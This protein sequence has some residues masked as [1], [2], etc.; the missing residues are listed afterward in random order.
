M[1]TF[2]IGTTI[3]TS[4]AWVD[5][6]GLMAGTYRFRLE[7]EDAAG[8][9]SNPAEI[10]VVVTPPPPPPPPPPPVTRP[11]ITRQPVDPIEDRVSRIPIWKRPGMMEP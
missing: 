11:P 8:I 6:D 5:V 3:V 4:D 2:G 1:A 10:S 7:V 9:L